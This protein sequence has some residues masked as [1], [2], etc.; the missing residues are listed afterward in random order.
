MIYAHCSLANPKANLKLSL[1]ENLKLNTNILI[2]LLAI[3][4]G[5]A[6]LQ[7]QKRNKLK[8]KDQDHTQ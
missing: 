6:M 2:C 8:A 1:T 4:T 3:P 7:D 5:L